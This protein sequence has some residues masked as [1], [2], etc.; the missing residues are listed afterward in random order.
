M[1]WWVGAIAFVLAAFGLS[2]VLYAFNVTGDP[3]AAILALFHDVWRLL[4]W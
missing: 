2:E 4:P 1:D 3:V